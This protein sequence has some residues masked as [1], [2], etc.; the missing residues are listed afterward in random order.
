MDRLNIPGSVIAGFVALTVCTGIVSAD[1]MLT[2]KAVNP[3]EISAGGTATVTV[4]VESQ[5][6]TNDVFPLDVMI[7]IDTSETM[8]DPMD[9]EATMKLLG[10]VAFA[11]AFVDELGLQDQVGLVTFGGEAELERA[12]SFDRQGTIADILALPD[13][14]GNPGGTTPIADGIETAHQHL[15]SN[16]RAGAVPKIILLSDGIDTAGGTEAAALQAR[17]EGT[18]IMTISYGPLDDQFPDPSLLQLAV[19]SR[20]PSGDPLHFHEPAVFEADDVFGVCFN[21]VANICAR[22]INILEAV[23]LPLE[24]TQILS[25]EYIP[26]TIG[27]DQTNEA[28]VLA[29]NSV[30]MF[31]HQMHNDD[32]YRINFEVTAEDCGQYD[33]D[34]PSA[35][36]EWIGP[37]GQADQEPFPQRQLTV[38]GCCMAVCDEEL[39]CETDGDFTYTFD[40]KNSS[41]VTAHWLLDSGRRHRTERQLGHAEPE[42][43]STQ[44]ASAARRRDHGDNPAGYQRCR[45][46]R[47][48][49]LPTHPHR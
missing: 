42:C 4:S 26:G 46:R 22:E 27:F 35:R 14:P 20:D 48:G 49:V 33:V 40:I 9:T 7:V 21:H 30:S 32:L 36:V 5:K 1:D 6:T 2:S 41:G 29:G 25:V 8:G 37:D 44:S 18:T 13:V 34:D 28:P 16:G 11:A 24:V 39:L 47:G 10:A 31:V 17:A 23:M 38:S 43:D 45:P 15:M 3:S 12:L 19:P